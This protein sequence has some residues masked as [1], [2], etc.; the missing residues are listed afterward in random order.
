MDI[1]RRYNAVSY[2]REVINFNR[3]LNLNIAL[4]LSLKTYFFILQ[5]FEMS[6]F[7]KMPLVTQGSDL[8]AHAVRIRSL[9]H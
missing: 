1:M 2:F 3:Q 8:R 7:V 6:N 4:L 5:V 9:Y